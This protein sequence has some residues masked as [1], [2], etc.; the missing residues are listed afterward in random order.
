VAVLLDRLREAGAPEQAAAL[1]ARLPAAGLFKFFLEQNGSA[2][3]FHFGR[4]ADGTPAAPW[5]GK[6]WTYGLFML[7]ERQHS[8]LLLGSPAAPFIL[9]LA[10]GDVARFLSDPR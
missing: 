7:T 1:T 2:D 6:T 9:A 8:E 5:A 10:T 4:E 3:Q